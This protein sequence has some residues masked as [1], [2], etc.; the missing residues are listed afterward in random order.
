MRRIFLITAACFI[1]IT[2]CARHYY[3]RITDSELHIHINQPGAEKVFILCSFDGYKPREAINNGSGRWE[4][5]L[6]ANAE[7]K[8]F[9]IV[10]EKVFIPECKMKETDDFGDEN[11]VYIPLLGST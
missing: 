2:G 7:F 4:S 5:I 1:L 6:P 8:Y 3:Y 9:Y 10:D 11:C